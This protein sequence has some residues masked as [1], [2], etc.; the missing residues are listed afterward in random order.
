MDRKII[1]VSTEVVVDRV[2]AALQPGAR[3]TGSAIQAAVLAWCMDH[4]AH[5]PGARAV[6][7]A[8]VKRGCRAMKSNGKRYWAGPVLRER[9]APGWALVEGADRGGSDPLA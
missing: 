4:W 1:E 3:C 5:P 6:A 9:G 8:L 2:L 7:A